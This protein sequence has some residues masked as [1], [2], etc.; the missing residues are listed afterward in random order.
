MRFPSDFP[1]ANIEPDDPTKKFR[2]EATESLLDIASVL[3]P[4]KTLDLCRQSLVREIAVHQADPTA[5]QG[6][7]VSLYV[8]IHI[9]AYSSI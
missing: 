7:E 1:D 8:C 4:V 6:V 9:L 3:G 2:N 5:W